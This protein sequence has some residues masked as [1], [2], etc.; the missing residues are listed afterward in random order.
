[1]HHV[2]LIVQ[3][4][5]LVT[6]KL[7]IQMANIANQPFG[8]MALVVFWRPHA[9]RSVCLTYPVLPYSAYI[10]EVTLILFKFKSS[11]QINYLKSFKI[12][13]NFIVQFSILSFIFGIPMLWLQMCLG[14]N[15]KGGP[16]SMW[17]VSPICK[18][19]IRMFLVLKSSYCE[20][21]K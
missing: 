14:A 11:N 5:L 1:M 12:T 21:I 18:V 7:E 2:I 4:L 6:A 8:Q 13:A 15:I 20:F 10:S 17:R 16:I 9:V 3:Q 19:A